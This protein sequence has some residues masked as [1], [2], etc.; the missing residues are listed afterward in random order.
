MLSHCNPLPGRTQSAGIALNK[1]ITYVP[2]VHTGHPSVTA[3]AKAPERVGD[4]ARVRAAEAGGLDSSIDLDKA[5]RRGRF[6]VA[7]PRATRGGARWADLWRSHSSQ[8]Y[9]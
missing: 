5:R 6:H 8:V 9:G 3:T 7:V 1:P 4:E 2:Y